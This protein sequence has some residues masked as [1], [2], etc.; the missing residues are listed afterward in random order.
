MA[1]VDVVYVGMVC[2]DGGGGDKMETGWGSVGGL[3]EYSDKTIC[4]SWKCLYQQTNS[5]WPTALKKK[6]KLYGVL[7]VLSLYI[8]A[9]AA[10]S[11]C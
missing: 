10:V 11:F 5:L 4:S 7:L 1:C 3:E 2:W 9:V 8:I 6:K